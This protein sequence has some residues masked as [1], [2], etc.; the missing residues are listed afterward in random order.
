MQLW[1]KYKKTSDA[2]SAYVTV[3]LTSELSVSGLY[4][5]FQDLELLTLDANTSYNFIFYIEDMFGDMTLYELDVV[6]NQ[7]T[8]L[9]SF[10]K[11]TTQ[12]NRPRV[13]I[14]NPEPYYELDVHGDISM[15]DMLVLGYV[16]NLDDESLTSLK[17]GGYYVQANA[18]A[19]STSLGY[20]AVKAGILEVFGA[21]GGA[22]IQRYTPL[23]ATAVYIRAY[24]GSSW[25][26]W[27]SHALS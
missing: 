24:S 6:L 9:M 3:D 12:N 16:A 8:P 19:A 11:R 25:T 15:R 23:D 20:P 27:K 1:F 5:T 18:S 10:R 22:I 13:G 2:A 17:S 14:N 4:F 26:S 7:G 21:P